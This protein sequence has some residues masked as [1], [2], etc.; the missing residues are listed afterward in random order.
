MTRRNRIAQSK[1][2]HS[3]RP[4]RNRPNNG[5]FLETADILE[6]EPDIVK[7]L[8]KAEPEINAGSTKMWKRKK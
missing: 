4:Q 3:Q 1:K 7:K 5:S 8:K 6:T 2:R